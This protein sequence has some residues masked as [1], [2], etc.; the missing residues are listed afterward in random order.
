M[1]FRPGLPLLHGL[2]EVGDGG[3]EE[4]L[5]DVDDGGDPDR[6][7]DVPDVGGLQAVPGGGAELGEEGSEDLGEGGGG[8]V[9]D[10][11]Q[12]AAQDCQDRPGGVRSS[13]LEVRQSWTR[14]GQAGWGRSETSLV[15]RY[16][17]AG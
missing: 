12:E 10:E 17:L 2:Q 14:R 8:Q 16:S 6:P 15:R 11:R 5:E 13:E 1:R 3:G 4:R 9:G 7:P